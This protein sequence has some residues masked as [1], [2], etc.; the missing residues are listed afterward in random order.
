MTPPR[1]SLSSDTFTV[2]YKLIDN[3]TKVKDV[4]MLKCPTN[5]TPELSHLFNYQLTVLNSIWIRDEQLKVANNEVLPPYLLSQLVFMFVYRPMRHWNGFVTLTPA[6]LLTSF[7]HLWSVPSLGLWGTTF[8]SHLCLTC[9]EKHHR[10]QHWLSHGAVGGIQEAVGWNHCPDE[11]LP[12][13]TQLLS[14][15]NQKR[16]A[17]SSLSHDLLTLHQVYQIYADQVEILLLSDDPIDAR[18]VWLFGNDI[19]N[20]NNKS[21]SKDEQLKCFNTSP[22]L[23]DHPSIASVHLF[24]HLMSLSI[25]LL[26]SPQ[27]SSTK[28]ISTGKSVD[29]LRCWYINGHISHH[30]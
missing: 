20:D 17:P 29:Y 15:T 19:T 18:H 24:H 23:L 2:Q 1:W 4:I 10:C 13:P 16:S 7:A 12:S 11:S 28:S 27:S 6:K 22:L 26:F 25:P 30:R 5:A 21:D 9:S 14:M 3:S 8:Q